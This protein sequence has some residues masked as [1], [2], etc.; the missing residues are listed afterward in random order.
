MKMDRAR[1][2]ELLITYIEGQLSGEQ[3]AFV[4]AKIKED[5]V[6]RKMYHDYL[7]LY[8]M[9]EDSPEEVPED[10]LSQ[11]FQQ[12]LEREKQSKEEKIIPIKGLTKTIWFKVAASVALIAIGVLIGRFWTENSSRD[13]EIMVLQ[14]DLEETKMLLNQVIDGNLSATQRLAHVQVSYQL[15]NADSEILDVLIRT[16]NTDNNV[17]VRIA[18]IRALSGFTDEQ[19]V[20]RAFIQSLETQ[21][22][23]FIQTMLI[24]ILVKIREKGAVKQ[25]E[26]LIENATVDPTVKDEAQLGIFQLS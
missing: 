19:K 2:E 1:I 21:E 6:I 26:K 9:M 14:Q 17:N 10:W 11:D 16:M 25:F 15:E 18:A 22:D 3:K 8:Q 20:R 13:R 24:N 4:E 23:P 5:T 12:M 7:A